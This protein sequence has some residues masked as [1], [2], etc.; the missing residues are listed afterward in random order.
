MEAFC[1]NMGSH[2]LA[3]IH[4]RK[5]LEEKSVEMKEKW[6]IK[7][8]TVLQW[9]IEWARKCLLKWCEHKSTRKPLDEWRSVLSR[10][11]Q[12]RLFLSWC[13][14]R[15][16]A[17]RLDNVW[18][19]ALKTSWK[20]EICFKLKACNVFRLWRRGWGGGAKWFSHCPQ[21]PIWAE[22]TIQKVL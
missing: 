11:A 3:R 15:E 22:T 8:R 4:S 9:I 12:V 18:A 14:C 17:K 1:C 20:L 21:V 16:D 7:R 2:V 19:A 6:G 5:D 10:T 13:S